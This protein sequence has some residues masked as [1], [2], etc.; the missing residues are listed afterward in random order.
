MRRPR[1]TQGCRDDDDDDDDDDELH[2][3][4]I[5]VLPVA[6]SHSITDISKLVCKRTDR[7]NSSTWR[8]V[9]L[10]TTNPTFTGLRSNPGLCREWSKPWHG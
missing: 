1:S 9:T 3:T 5:M 8:S 6:V 4:E 10:Y 7:E 2:E